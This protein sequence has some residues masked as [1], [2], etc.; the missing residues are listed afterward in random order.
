MYMSNH[1]TP[2]NIYDNPVF[3]Q[4]YRQLREQDS[5]LNGALE[6]P[7]LRSLLPDLAGKRILDLG[8]GF[9]DFARHA[10]A[11]GALAVTALDVS[12]SMI[13]EARRL[14]GDEPIHYLHGSMEDFTATAQSFDLV[15]SSLALHYIEDYAALA[16][17]LFTALAPGGQF[18]FSVEHPTCSAYPV[19]WVK[20]EDG[21]RLHWPLNNYQYEGERHSEWFVNDVRKYHRTVQTYVNTLINVGFRLD[22]LGEPTP[23]ASFLSERP[24]LEAEWRRPAFLL[25]AVS[26]G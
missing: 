3:F 13:T 15:I 23:L 6:I 11:Q 7:A 26:K 9:G 14:T 25:L 5:G 12:H 10:C 1:A 2:Q 20:A 18:V 19:G 24:G 4:G 17:R 16:Q 21:T 8:C 22:H